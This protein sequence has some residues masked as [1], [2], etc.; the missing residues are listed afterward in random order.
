M[1]VLVMGAGAVGAYFG[2]LLA[3]AGHGVTLVARGA[4]LQA[5]QASSLRVQSRHGDFT[6]AVR[7]VADPSAA[8]TPDL[9]LFTVKTYDTEAAARAL[10]PALGANSVVL[11]LQN[12]VDSVRDLQALLGNRVLGGAVYIESDILEPGLVRQTSPMRD[13][14]LGEPGGRSQRAEAVHG[15]LQAAGIPVTL[16]EKIDYAIWQKFVMLASFSGITAATRLPIGPVR[17]CKETWLLFRQLVAEACAAGYARGV[18]FPGDTVET[19]LARVAA[20]DPSFKSS[21]LR[22]L[23]KGRR[24]EVDALSGAV[25]RLGREAGAPA[26][27]HAAI[28]ALLKPYAAGA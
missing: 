11:T 24:L 18:I 16:A 26:P 25:A 3:Q 7:A 12:G 9:V 14:V 4:H 8:P 22:D 28:Y 13:I 2:G 23:E 15:V 21:M 27:G 10:A 5:L 19:I 6:A 20:F 17:D 1:H